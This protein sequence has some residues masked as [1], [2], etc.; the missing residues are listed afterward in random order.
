MPQ[1]IK[2]YR[3]NQESYLFKDISSKELII[4]KIIKETYKKYKSK[5]EFKFSQLPRFEYNTLKY[6]LFVHNFN[7]KETEW[8]N[9]LPPQLT[10]NVEL[11]TKNLT[12]F[13]FISNDIDIFVVVGGKGYEAIIPFLDHSFGLTVLSKIIN[14]NED[15]V[16]SINSRGLTGTRSGISEQYRS[17][18][19]L[20]DYARFG[21]VPVEVH[22][23]LNTQISNEYFNFLQNK[24]NEKI[25]IYAGKSFKVKKNLNFDELNKMIVELGFILER[26]ANDY[27]STYIEVKDQKVIKNELEP[28]LLKAL[29]DDREFVFGRETTDKRFKFDLC[30]PNKMTQFYEADYYVLKEKVDSEDGKSKYADFARLENREDIYNNVM[31]HAVEK[32]EYIDFVKFRAYIQGVRIASYIDNKLSTSASFIYHF[33]SEFQYQG[34]SIFLVD[35]KWYI[36]NSSFIED[37]KYECQNTLRNYRLQDGILNLPWDKNIISTEKKYNLQYDKTENYIVLDAVIAD[38]VELCD[39][40]YIQD[41][42]IYLIHVKYGFDSSLRELNNQI[43]LSAKRLQDDS[44]SG[45]FSYVDKIYDIAAS[46]HGSMSNYSKEE[47][48]EIIKRKKTY[49]FAFASQ[50]SDDQLVEDSIDLYKSNIARYSLVQCCKDMVVTFGYDIKFHQIRRI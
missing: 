20:I 1:S 17:E 37:L 27:L 15:I 41:D 28:L 13:L 45:N 29:Y 38:G 46:K 10:Q 14:P 21:R 36:L 49:V 31:R 42:N 35:T 16:V 33:T 39:V 44:K 32:I 11:N 24:E 2:I 4:E 43:I 47:F 30:D 5:E 6:F 25:K 26:E 7:E 12:L 9:F 18:F 34:K 19:K 48:R 50:L 40:L 8:N 23:I 22:L 3:I